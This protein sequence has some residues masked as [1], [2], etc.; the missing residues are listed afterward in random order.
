MIF[1][2]VNN[3]NI[4]VVNNFIFVILYT[5]PTTGGAAPAHSGGGGGKKPC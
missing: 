4:N 2:V 3:D 1:N 5:R